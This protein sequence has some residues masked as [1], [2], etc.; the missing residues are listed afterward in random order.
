MEV[1]NPTRNIMQQLAEKYHFHELS[2]EDSLSKIEIPKIDK[3]DDHI[4][5]TIH[6][7]VIDDGDDQETTTRQTLSDISEPS[8]GTRILSKNN[9]CCHISCLQENMFF[10]FYSFD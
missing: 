8:W 9:L 5:T 7:P 2:I 10:N 3:Y 1:Q 6:I 4:F